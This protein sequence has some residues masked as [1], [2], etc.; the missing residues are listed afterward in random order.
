VFALIQRV[1]STDVTVLV[2]GESGTGKELVA[3]AIHEA[4]PRRQRPFVPINCGAIP[5]TLLESELFGHERGAFTDAHRAREGVSSWP[6]TARCY[7]TRS[8][9]FRCISRSSF[10]Y[11]NTSSAR[12]LA[13]PCIGSR[14]RRHE[15]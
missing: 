10:G 15:P 4:S 13:R 12:R 9:R 11:S 3:N 2:L 8:A 5:E 7:W 6:I 1:A 14:H